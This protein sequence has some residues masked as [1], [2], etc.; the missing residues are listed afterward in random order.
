M[1]CGQENICNISI[2]KDEFRMK[3]IEG[4]WRENTNKIPR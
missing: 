1:K 4:L 2:R 3:G